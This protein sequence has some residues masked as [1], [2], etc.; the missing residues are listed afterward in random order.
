MTTGG[1]EQGFRAWSEYREYPEADMQRRA[2]AF[3]EDIHRRR[4]IRDFD[5]RPVPKAV[6]QECIRAA[7]AAP[8]GAHMQPWRFVAVSDPRIKKRI[9]VAAEEEER[10]FYEH[11]ASAEWLEALSM[12]GTTAEKPFLETAPWLIAIF[13]ERWGLTAGGQR[14]KHYYPT[15]SVGIATGFLIAA[16]HNAGLASLT[17][18]PSPMKFLNEILGRPRNERP[19]LLLV[20]GYPAEK[21]SVP[22][23]ERKPLEEVAE[24]L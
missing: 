14:R 13:E 18:T 10:H 11:R 16:L 5:D 22:T 7:T 24:F 17:H 23:L 6:I 4:T 21:A 9:R 12:L 20:A 2:T 8:S 15:E 1:R 3:R 19:F